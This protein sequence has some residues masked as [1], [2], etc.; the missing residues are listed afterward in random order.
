[1]A[2]LI[3]PKLRH[4]V[5]DWIVQRI[6][7]GRFEPGTPLPAER[8]LATELGVGRS[9]VREAVRVLEQ[10]GVLEV[11]PGKGTFLREDAPSIATLM[12]VR[13]AAVG[14]YSPLDLMEAR[15]ELEPNASARAAAHCTD[16]DR[17]QL[18]AALEEQRATTTAGGDPSGADRLVHL[19]IARIGRNR[20]SED[21]IKSCVLAME[22]RSWRRVRDT[23]WTESDGQRANLSE[24]EAICAR[25]VAG[26]PEG[27]RDLMR[28]HLER[29]RTQIRLILEDRGFVSP[30]DL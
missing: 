29:V 26:D 13:T 24:H 17:V 18:E 6:A 21:L 28:D 16:H 9:S 11:R 20:V 12:R 2:T 8:R 25:I 4:E 22:H 19:E 5:A 23:L 3:V 15:L 30:Y 14:E 10:L 1:M 27:A 7:D